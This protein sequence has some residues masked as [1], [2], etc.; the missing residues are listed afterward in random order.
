MDWGTGQ[1]TVFHSSFQ[2]ALGKLVTLHLNGPETNDTP[3]NHTVAFKSTTEGLGTR[4]KQLGG[5]TW[6]PSDLARAWKQ[7][8]NELPTRG[9]MF[10]HVNAT[11]QQSIDPKYDQ[12][13]SSSAETLV[14]PLT[15]SFHSGAFTRHSSRPRRCQ[16]A[17]LTSIKRRI[18]STGLLIAAVHCS[19]DSEGTSSEND[20]IH[21]VRSQPST[22]SVAS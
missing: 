6:N 11:Q 16:S 14:R 4:Q 19:I 10:D 9:V 7:T 12:P 22:M 18:A 1:H 21:A 17:S 8:H 3:A 13:F 5:S 15:Q 20:T 2:D